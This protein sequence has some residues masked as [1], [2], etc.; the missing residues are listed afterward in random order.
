MPVDLG[1]TA[2]FRYKQLVQLTLALYLLFNVYINSSII[3]TYNQKFFFPLFFLLLLG[4]VA[5][6]KSHS[7]YFLLFI[8]GAT[9]FFF[10]FRSYD[11]QS[12]VF[13]LAVALLSLVLLVKHR[14]SF[15][16]SVGNNFFILLL[17]LYCCLAFCSLLLL[18]LQDIFAKIRLWGVHDFSFFVLNA[19]PELPEYS[20]AAV[21]R[22]LLFSLAAGLLAYSGDSAEQYFQCIFKGAVW[23]L[24]LAAIIG[25]LEYFNALSLSWYVSGSLNKLHSLFL[26]RGWYAEY[27]ICLTPLLF[28]GICRFPGRLLYSSVLFVVLVI[29]GAS[30]LFTGARSGWGLFAVLL[31]GS[32][33]VF[34]G[35]GNLRQKMFK[36]LF[37]FSLAILLLFTVSFSIFKISQVQDEPGVCSPKSMSAKQIFLEKRLNNLFRTGRIK[38][39]QDTVQLIDGRFLFGRGYESFSRQAHILAG[40]PSSA[41]KRSQ[42]HLQIRDTA[43]NFYLQL[44]VSNGFVGLFVW[45]FLS[46]YASLVLL[47]DYRYNNN[48][49]SMVVFMCILSFHLYGLTQSLQ[50]VPMIWF[51]IFLFFGYAMMREK[52]IGPQKYQKKVRL[53]VAISAFSCLVAVSSYALNVG[54]KQEAERYG[55]EVF[56]VDQDL[57]RFKGFYK[58][59]F[60]PQQGVYRWSGRQAEIVLD[61]DGTVVIDFACYAPRLADEPLVL[62]VLLDSVPLDRY[63]FTQ[64]GSVRRA[65]S[66]QQQVETIGK[67]VQI[68]VS[69]TW[70][71]RREGV[72]ADMRNLGVAVSEPKWGDDNIGEE[73]K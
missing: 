73:G 4:L 57:Y 15:N 27:V 45:L 25:L 10:G 42:Q 61:K 71:P 31:A 69:R 40:I 22:L 3:L 72:S 18:P 70:N 24:V 28:L 58:K 29:V 20:I 43:H 14:N 41:Y 36:S 11:V 32:S 44:L 23:G 62:D 21:N 67:T 46:G 66:I 26:N 65:Y 54:L 37:F 60:W 56:A 39:W 64:A 8:F 63:T 9:F 59:E 7:L 50:Y 30:I 47:R 38:N 6:R 34:V 55:L 51:L 53:V 35:Q 48:C 5:V 16:W 52:V 17:L 49:E 12:R 68:R 13:E 33:F 1:G 19:T 2:L